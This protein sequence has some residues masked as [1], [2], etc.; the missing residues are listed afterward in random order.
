MLNGRC[1]VPDF[2][3]ESNESLTPRGVFVFPQITQIFT[4][5]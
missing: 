3:H 5:F 4:D 2:E 1:A